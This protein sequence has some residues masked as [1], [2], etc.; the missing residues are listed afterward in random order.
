MQRSAPACSRV[1]TTH[2]ADNPTVIV[3]FLEAEVVVNDFRLPRG[4]ATLTGLIRDMREREIEKIT[5][6]RGVEASDI[7]ALMEELA[8]RTRAPASATD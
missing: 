2:L 8:E 6:A 3:A 4:T 1:C 7:R 5:F